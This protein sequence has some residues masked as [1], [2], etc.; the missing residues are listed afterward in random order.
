M[1]NVYSVAR[2]NRYIKHMISSDFLLG[3]IQ[4][5]GEVSNTVYNRSGHIYFTLKDEYSSLDCVMFAGN[6]HG[7][8]FQMKD[9]DRVVVTGGVD[10]YEKAGSYKL[11]ARKI[12]LYGMGILYERFLKLKNELEERGMFAAEYKKEIPAF[13]KRLGVVTAATGAAIRDIA[14]ISKR[15]HPGIEII[16]YP[17]VVQGE[18]AA[19][20]IVRGIETLDRSGVD[21]IIAGRG[22]GSIEDLWAFNEEE[23][24]YAI[25]H[26]ETPVIS[27]VG[28]ET[29]FTI[30]DFVADLRAPTPSAA[31]ELAVPDICEILESLNA[32]ERHLDLL[33][34]RKLEAAILR[35]KAYAERLGAL[36]PRN[37]V[38]RSRERLNLLS[39]RLQNGAGNHLERKKH[40]L[41]LLSERLDGHS[42]LKK[43]SQGYS[44]V[45][46]GTGKAVTSI[47]NVRP[48]DLLTIH[49]TDGI[50]EAETKTITE[51]G[52]ANG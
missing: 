39:E 1:N 37:R 28:H 30:A 7:L 3:N 35:N 16:L 18:R 19:E 42:P 48:G 41:R 47:R 43:L 17:A 24:A 45:S 14:S 15:R 51:A 5:E 23:V 34:K 22:G 8:G 13:P 52:I 27:A 21:V 26:C 38:L 12:A 20:S 40:R 10:V 29:D 2:V 49:V 4:V 36:S 11:Y 46:A 9:G 31:A 44:Y 50:I 33:M 32:A 25:F 6:R